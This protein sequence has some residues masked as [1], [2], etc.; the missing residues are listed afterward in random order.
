MVTVAFGMGVDCKGLY[1]VIHYGPPKS[2]DGYLKESGRVGRDRE[3][4]S[5]IF[6]LY[7]G[8]SR[9]PHINNE[10]KLYCKNEEVCRRIIG[11]LRID[12]AAVEDAVCAIFAFT[13]VNANAL[14]F[15]LGFSNKQILY[16]F[17]EFKCA[18]FWLIYNL[19]EAKWQNL[20][21]N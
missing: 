16:H 15:A 21:Y 4:S 11:T 9:S 3:Q 7:K 17:C 8:Y 19:K 6:L 2:L 13:N 5:A 1:P 10:M 18:I 14:C 12:N 20:L